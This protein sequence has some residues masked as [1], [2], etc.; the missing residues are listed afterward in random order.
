MIPHGFRPML[1]VDHNKVSMQPKTLYMSEKLD[2]VRVLFFDGIAYSRA[3][4]PLPNRKLQELAKIHKKA[5]EGCDGELISGSM[6][7]PDVLQRSVS[8]AMSFHSQDP[9]KIYLFDKFEPNTYWVNRFKK[10]L[11]TELPDFVSVLGHY[12][13]DSDNA[14]AQFESEVLNRGGEGVMLRDADGMY[15]FGRSGTRYPELQ[16]VKRFKD[17]EVKILDFAPLQHN[18]NEPTI[19]DLG[20]TTRSTSKEGMVEL[21]KLGSLHVELPNGVRFWVGGGFTEAQR[22]MYWRMREDIVGKQA[23][24]K[25]FRESADGVP[26]LPTF[27]AFRD[28]L[29]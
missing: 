21:D 12:K 25:Y 9:F 10:L 19:D 15:K 4:K 13:V 29:V 14:L 3:L 23:T 28:D 24:I 1:A 17:C 26:L 2:G 16:K 5:L 27:V 18:E 20:Y 7:G 8:A 6:Y 22:V 11:T